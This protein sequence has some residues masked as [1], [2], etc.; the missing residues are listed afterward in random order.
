[1]WILKYVFRVSDEPIKPVHVSCLFKMHAQTVYKSQ[2]KAFVNI[3]SK[4][5]NT[6]TL[7]D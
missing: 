5:K 3:N 4:V 7:T 1:M 2:W 6:E